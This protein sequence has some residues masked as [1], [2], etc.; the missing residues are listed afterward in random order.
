V[1]LF[2]RIIEHIE[3]L[4]NKVHDQDTKLPSLREQLER[5]TQQVQILMAGS[6]MHS[7]LM[8][9]SDQLYVEVLS[10]DAGIGTAKRLQINHGLSS[11]LLEDDD[12]DE[13]PYNFLAIGGQA[14][15]FIGARAIITPSHIAPPLVEDGPERGH[16][17]AIAGD[18]GGFPAYISGEPEIVG[19]LIYYPWR[20]YAYQPGTANGLHDEFEASG[21]ELGKARWRAAFDP[22]VGPRIV[23]PIETPVWISNE[24]QSG[25][26]A[27]LWFSTPIEAE[28]DL[29]C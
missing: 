21:V 2:P 27:K 1:A 8:S 22:E 25:G 16:W 5:L 29:E 11:I 15:L 26:R 13:E 4:W 9:H 14:A 18:G 3:R 28:S 7:P 17:L 24:V 19:D 10:F 23:L 6:T 20:Q 12:E